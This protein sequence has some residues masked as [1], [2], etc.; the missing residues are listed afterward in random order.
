ML[1]TPIFRLLS[2]I[3]LTIFLGSAH[4]ES[5]QL[6][7]FSTGSYQQLL[8]NHKEQPFMLVI[9]SLTC[10]SCVKDMALLNELHKSRPDIKMVMLATDDISESAQ[11]Q[12]LLLKNNLTSV[13]NWIYAD[14]NT[15]KLNYEID[16]Q[17]YGEQPRTYF[18]D[19]KHQ[20][21]GISGV[22]TKTDYEALFA[23][24]LKDVPNKP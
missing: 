8:T 1:R 24:I 19:A 3:I 2:F 22:I 17:W 13:E 6:K 21:T 9:W 14:D 5:P 10:P 18:F 16:P 4:A 7:S 12:A 20:R 11:V 23:K 15:Q